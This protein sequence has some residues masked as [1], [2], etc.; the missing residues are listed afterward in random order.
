MPKW[1]SIPGDRLRVG[2]TIEVWWNP[3]QD[4]ITALEPYVGPLAYL[5]PDG[6]RIAQF[7]LLKTGMTIDHNEAYRVL[8]A[9]TLD[10]C[11]PAY[12]P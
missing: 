2:M 5:W 8:S 1:I 11:D 9:T 4:T 3:H 6:A 10:L 7:A 12:H